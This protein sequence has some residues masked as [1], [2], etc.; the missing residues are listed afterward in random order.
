[1]KRIIIIL[2]A[3]LV[4]SAAAASVGTSAGSPATLVA[5]AK[6]TSN[7]TSL[8]IAKAQLKSSNGWVVVHATV[9]GKTGLNAIGA[10]V[11]Q[12][13]LAKGVLVTNVKVHFNHDVSSGKYIVMLHIDAGKPKKLE[14]RSKDVP[15][16]NNPKAFLMRTVTLT[17]G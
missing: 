12:L 16:G 1:M 9:P 14:I 8:T 6:Q 11:G 2:T 3:A 13:W 4:V 17:V 5:A 7:G 10:V 15:Y